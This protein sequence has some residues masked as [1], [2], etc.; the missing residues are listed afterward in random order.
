MAAGRHEYLLEYRQIGA[1]VKV[2]AIDPATG[3]EAAITGP[4]TAGQAILA[5]NA[6]NKLE[7][8]LRKRAGAGLNSTGR[9]GIEV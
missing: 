9:R 3:V 6:V 2:T 8:V 4:A 1:Y 7:Y 5:R